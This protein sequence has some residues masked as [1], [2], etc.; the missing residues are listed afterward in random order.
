VHLRCFPSLFIAVCPFNPSSQFQSWEYL[1]WASGSGER[2]EGAGLLLFRGKRVRTG[3][4]NEMTHKESL[5]Y[6]FLFPMENGVFIHNAI[7]I[8]ITHCE[9]M[10][11][12]SI[13]SLSMTGL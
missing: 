9:E 1:G 5:F 2:K 8:S 11:P 4:K 6:I 13:F 7:V 3:K 10:K 12:G